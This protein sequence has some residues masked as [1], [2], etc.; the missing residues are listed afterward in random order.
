MKFCNNRRKKVKEKKKLHE[1]VDAHKISES[2]QNV[3][4]QNE[5]KESVCQKISKDFA[6]NDY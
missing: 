1:K 6:W 5:R 3:T 2:P 4:K